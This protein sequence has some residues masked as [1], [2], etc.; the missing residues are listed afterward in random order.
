M[1][2]KDLKILLSRISQGDEQA[3]KKLFESYRNRLFNYI[4]KITKSR[5][6]TEE[7]VM[8]VFLKLWDGRSLIADIENF[9][10]FIFSVARNKS[11]DFLRKVAKDP[12]LQELIRDEIQI[13]SDFRTDEKF[14]VHELVE[15]VNR[16]VAQ[17]SSQRQVVF[18][19]SREEHMNYDQ[20][21][22]HLN[23][24]KSTIKNHMVDALKFIREHLNTHI[25][26]A[27]L[28]LLLF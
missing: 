25:D 21:A 26:C 12:I 23:L 17:L 14:I 7:I 1:V 5:E 11:I 13:M 18:R 28:A 10:S 27:I 22:K 15:E 9:P 3:F 4:L 19:L 16:V 24:S 20:I 2:D 8:D 6:I